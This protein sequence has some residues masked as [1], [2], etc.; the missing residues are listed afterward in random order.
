ME[1]MMVFSGV[2][3][4][5][6]TIGDAS[7]PSTGQQQTWGIKDPATRS[8]WAGCKTVARLDLQN[9][10][11]DVRRCCCQ[12]TGKLFFA[13]ATVLQGSRCN[14]VAKRC[15][16]KTVMPSSQRMILNKG[17]GVVSI[18]R[19]SVQRRL[20]HA[21]FSTK[22]SVRA[23]VSSLPLGGGLTPLTP[24]LEFNLDTPHAQN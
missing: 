15:K 20:E 10:S 7:S 3:N 16:C 12:F 23:H 17:N 5:R 9:H 11:F 22:L 8:S 18:Q 21:A 13:F 2:Y 1:N 6:N 24:P 19:T 4:G 14:I